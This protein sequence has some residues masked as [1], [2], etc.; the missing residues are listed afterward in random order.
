MDI[1]KILA[2]ALI[3]CVAT[4]IVKQVKPDFASLVTLAGGIIILLMLIDYINQIFQVLNYIVEKT[5]L[6][7]G[8]FG[9]VLKI[10]GIGYLTEFT[11]NICSDSDSTSLANKVLL[12][13]K[14]IILVMALPILTNIIDI[15]IDI[16]P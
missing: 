15:I 2:I 16:L 11:A 8:L 9:I 7:P 12:A 1:F 6:S 14:I 3:T 5:N 13:G 4:L 10:I